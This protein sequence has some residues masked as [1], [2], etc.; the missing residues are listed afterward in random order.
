[1]TTEFGQFLKEWRGV[2]RFSQLSL[3]L[4]ADMSARH[5]SFFESG[6][7]KPSRAMVLRLSEALQLPRPTANQALLMAGFVPAYPRLAE[8]APEL[9]PINQ[10]IESMLNSHDPLPGI[11]IDRHWNIV[12]ANKGAAMLLA[13]AGAEGPVNLVETLINNAE[14]G[15]I[16]NWEE[17]AVLTAAR[18]RTEILEYGGD[19][20][21]SALLKR[22]TSLE[23]SRNVDLDSINLNQAVIPTIM[24][25]GELRLSLFSAIT[26][27]GSVQDIRVGETRVELMFPMDEQTASFF[28]QMA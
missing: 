28:H 14:L 8:D 12:T 25:V 18:I 10:A 9:T 7:A 13:T 22:L 27:F 20:G 15:L 24:N 21:L 5:L 6:R 23:R 26:Q 17:V 1:M 16:T 3:S 11:A 4:E 2:R 19:E